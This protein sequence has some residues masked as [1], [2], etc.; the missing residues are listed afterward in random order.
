METSPEIEKI[1]KALWMF[2]GQVAGITKDSTNPFFHSKYAS[3]DNIVATIKPSLEAAHLSFSQ[4]PDGDGLTTI[5]M[6]DSGQWIKATAK[7]TPKDQTPQG[8]GSA[9]TYMRRYALS[10]AL[11]L[12]TEEDDDGNGPVASK[13][14]PTTKASKKTDYP[15]M[16]EKNNASGLKL[17]GSQEILAKKD[18]IKALLAIQGKKPET[19]L[20]N[21][22]RKKW[23]EN[24]VFDLTG[25]MLIEDNYDGIIKQLAE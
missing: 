12:A 21:E 18:R 19:T 17:T 24:Q 9:I 16:T 14:A 5:V 10:A 13:K 7:L 11:G 15:A 6:H 4:M 3:F 20:S 25:M 2:Q 22:E 23:F 8:Q 1:A